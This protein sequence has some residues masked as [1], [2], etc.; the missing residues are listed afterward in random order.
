MAKGSAIT[1]PQPLSK[2]LTEFVGKSEMS[3]GEV[4]KK[5]WEYIKEKNLQN[6]Q[7]KREILCNDKLETLLG[8][9][10]INMFKMTAAISK[11]IG[12]A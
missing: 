1:K 12:K 9:K 2:E 10:T 8:E 4:M 11:H 6:P 5:I 3:R 7:N